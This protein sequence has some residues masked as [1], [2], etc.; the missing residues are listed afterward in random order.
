[1]KESLSCFSSLNVEVFG[2]KLTQDQKLLTTLSCPTESLFLDCDFPSL[3][4][5]LSRSI[6]AFLLVLIPDLGSLPSP[7]LFP[8]QTDSSPSLRQSENFPKPALLG[9]DDLPLDFHTLQSK[10]SHSRCLFSAWNVSSANG[11]PA[12]P[13]P[14]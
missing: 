3:M 10:F 11:P 12:R 2:R 4:P 8:S 1:M 5:L 13:P 9:Y 14:V 6:P 7:L